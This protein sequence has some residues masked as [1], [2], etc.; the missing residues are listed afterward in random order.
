VQIHG[1]FRVE[2]E[3]GTNLMMEERSITNVD[4]A[5]VRLREYLDGLKDIKEDR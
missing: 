2:L 4:A 1:E 5:L 3:N